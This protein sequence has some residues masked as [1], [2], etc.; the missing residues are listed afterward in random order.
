[1][2]YGDVS[3]SYLLI[4]YD[5]ETGEKEYIYSIQNDNHGYPLFLIRKNNRWA[6]RSAKHYITMGEKLEIMCFGS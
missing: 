1:M 3:K 2:D 5:K 6:Y 4:M